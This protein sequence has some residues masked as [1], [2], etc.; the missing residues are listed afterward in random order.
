MKK[1]L[2]LLFLLPLC[3]LASCHDDDD[4]PNVDVTVTVSNVAVVDG[5]DIYVV[6]GDTLRVDGVSVKG[7]GS[8]ATI[9]SVTYALDGISFIVSPISPF[10][11]SLPSYNLKIGEFDLDLVF[12]LLQEDKTPATAAIDYD[13]HVVADKNAL[14]A[15]AEI[16][17]YA[18]NASIKAKDR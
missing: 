12:D 18:L 16:G 10:G 14:P 6:Q 9:Y 1:L 4:L 17:T 2:Y 7:N 5:D 8:R 3:M 15:G 11:L 13:V